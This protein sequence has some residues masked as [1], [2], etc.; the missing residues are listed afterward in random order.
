VKMLFEAVR[1]LH[2]TMKMLF[3]A[4]RMP[5]GGRRPGRQAAIGSLSHA[6][7]ASGA[8]PNSTTR[9]GR[10]FNPATTAPQSCIPDL[11]TSPL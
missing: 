4:V 3:E 11:S 2:E 9:L 10:Y 6:A 7:I 1:M 5:R 8:S